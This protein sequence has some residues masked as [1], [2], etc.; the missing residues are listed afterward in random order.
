MHSE[1]CLDP[2]GRCLY[3]GPSVFDKA[4]DSSSEKDLCLA[5]LI[6]PSLQV[7]GVEETNTSAPGTLPPLVRYCLLLL[8]GQED[9]VPI[10]KLRMSVPCG[11][12][13]ASDTSNLEDSAAPGQ[14]NVATVV[15]IPS[16][17]KVKVKRIT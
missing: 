9:L 5:E 13:C 6:R 1:C 12:A 2:Q 8:S 3:S 16:S 17:S 7:E 11:E 15:R 14:Q 4:K 10:C